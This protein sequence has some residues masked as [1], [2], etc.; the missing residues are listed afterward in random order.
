MQKNAKYI[1]DSALAHKVLFPVTV[2]ISPFG[3]PVG[4]NAILVPVSIIWVAR[5]PVCETS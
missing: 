4:K 5:Y 2:G 3:M 1:L